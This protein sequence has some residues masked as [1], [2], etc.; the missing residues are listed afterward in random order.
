MRYL[1][2]DII[3]PIYEPPINNGVI[4]IDDNG[5]IQELLNSPNGIDEKRIEFFKGALCPGFI[6]THCHLELSHLKGKVAEHTHIDGFV[7]ELQTKRS[8]SEEVISKAIEQADKEMWLNGIVAV[9]DI[10]NGN[11]TFQSKS[12]SKIYYHTFLELFGFNP[13]QAQE[14]F[15]RAKILEAELT[16][17][18][19]PSSIVPH[20]PY[21]VSNQLFKLIKSEHTSQNPICIHNQ[22]NKDENTFY[23]TGEGRLAKM[24][25]SFGISLN[26]WK[27]EHNSSL[28]G[29]IKKLPNCSNVL[30]VHNTF[31]SSQDIDFALESIENPFWCFCP[32]ANQYIENMLP[33]IN[34]FI[35]KNAK[36]T[37][38]T[39]SLAS[40]YTLSILDELKVI[41]SKF[42][43]IEL[44][45]L[46]KW[47]TLNG[48]E[49]LGI[50]QTF[51]SFEKEKSPGINWI[52]NIE[53]DTINSTSLIEKII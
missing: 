48:A 46:L 7:K 50:Q 4:V 2:A 42:P 23:Q 20:S 51:G 12:R 21:S 27:P 1:S 15:N 44:A 22:E 13:N 33:D 52:K 40:N 18:N 8:E 24:L 6:N 36:C 30:F 38:G 47:A 49:F 14:V 17:N 32:N 5:V 9:G 26:N 16:N 31:T 43:K 10:S 3:F 39:D 45:T 28:Q 19:L 41:S 11:A 37:I 34:L 25:E 35:D 53:N 29:Y